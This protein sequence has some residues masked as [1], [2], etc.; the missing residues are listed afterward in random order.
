[1]NLELKHF[2]IFVSLARTLHFGQAAEKLNMAQP[3]LSR[4]V[5]FI[6][7]EIGHP[8]LVRSTRKITLTAAGEVFLEQCLATIGQAEQALHLTRQTAIGR[9]GHLS[10]AYM[11]F[12]I[13]GP[14]PRILRAFR[15]KFESIDVRLN[16]M[17]SEQQQGAL[18]DREID[19]GFLIGPFDNPE[20]STI[21]VSCSR[22]MA[23]LPETHPLSN[24]AVIDL[25]SVANEPFVFGAMSQWRPFRDTVEKVCLRHGFM[26]K[27]I[28]EPFNSDAIF[29]FVAANLGITI[30][31]E[32]PYG[33][34]P[35]GVIAKPIEGVEDNIATV[36]AWHKRN[37]SKILHNFTE[38]VSQ[39]AETPFH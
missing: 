24:R 7:K 19:V 36:A 8:L 11:D 23:V 29:G 4:M 6:E 9:S 2:R 17:W 18:L 16:H 21:P 39:Y 38:T 34:Y 5:A 25:R 33:M 1:M 20:V 14:L 31:P 27:T 30:Y 15:S 22:L 13:S 37:P 35:R 26:P 12:A 3:Q 10:L 28:H 32:R